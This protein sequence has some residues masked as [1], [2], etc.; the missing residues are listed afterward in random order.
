MT[1][2]N[3]GTQVSKRQFRKPSGVILEVT[4][5]PSFWLKR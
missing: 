5:I 3:S 2:L 1:G 4:K